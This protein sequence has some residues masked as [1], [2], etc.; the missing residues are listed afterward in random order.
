M[1]EKKLCLAVGSAPTYRKEI[2]VRI[3]N[4]LRAD[5]V[6]GSGST[7]QMDRK[8]LPNKV[9]E[10]M[11]IRIGKTPFYRQT[12][13]LRSTRGY[14]KI[15]VSFG[16]FSISEWL[17][18]LVS[19]FRHQEIYA[20]THGWYGKEGRLKEWIKL[21]YYKKFTKIFVY[22][23]RARKMMIERGFAP[24]KIEVIYNSLAY[25]EQLK[26][27]QK[28]VPTRLYHDHFGNDNKNIIFV[29]RL[30]KVKQFNL[31][32]D[33]VAEIKR[34]GEL[35]NVTFIGDGE[36]RANM[37]DRV[38]KLNITEQVWF[39]GA[40]YDERT[41]AEMIYNADL[42]VSPGNIGLTAMHVMMFGCPAI[43]NDDFDH[44]M[45][46][47]EAINSGRTGSFFKAGDSS[48]LADA[49]SMWFKSSKREEVR[50]AC[51][52]EIDCKWNPNVQIEIFK[53]ALNEE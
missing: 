18:L 27:R 28:I 5:F 24:N 39:Y 10:I 2:F 7:K 43:T 21:F 50:L 33:A 15:I 11:T 8:L 44:Q 32:L 17:L 34:R 42:C 48:S 3:G 36:E 40:C 52:K 4:E 13:I 51:Y 38:K 26:I 30:T 23:E 16:I 29:G 31:L 14:N 53:K 9:T 25:S 12:G 22:G 49:I 6:V 47:F 20:W 19:K 41:N 46:E 1:E 37:E 35:I 45:P